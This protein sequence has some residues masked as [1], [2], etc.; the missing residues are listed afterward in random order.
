MR[1]FLTGYLMGLLLL[2]CAGAAQAQTIKFVTGNNYFPF[3]HQRMD[4]G[5]LATVYVRAVVE[6]MGITP[7]FEFMGWK[8]GYQAA[9]V[10]QYVGTFPYIYSEERNDQFHYSDPIFSVRPYIF[11]TARKYGG[12]GALKSLNGATLCVPK[13]W[14]VDGD[15][16]ELLDEGKIKVLAGNSVV[17][18]FKALRDGHVNA[19]SIDRRLGTIAARTV[20]KLY[21]YIA[22]RMSDESNPHY[23]IVSRRVPNG[24][25]WLD[26]FNE[27]LNRLQTEGVMYE[28]TSRYYENLE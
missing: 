4:G 12:V 6:A 17:G 7:E 16:Q 25:A 11:T 2:S 18:C 9:L 1:K 27:T 19:I 15:L 14:A 21:W 24:R 3:S 8:E 23:L 10:G 20:D 26:R 22:E 13:G 28:I 5:G